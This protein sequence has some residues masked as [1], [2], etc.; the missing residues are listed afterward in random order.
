MGD[1]D[2]VSLLIMFFIF[3]VFS[4]PVHAAE[5]LP[6]EVKWEAGRLSVVS[7]DTPLSD[8]LKKIT[9]ETGMKITGI[10]GAHDLITVNFSG[11]TLAEGIKRLMANNNYI[12]IYGGEDSPAHLYIIGW[13]TDI[14]Y[15][16]ERSLS[17]EL[18]EHIRSEDFD[19]RR[20]ALESISKYKSHAVEILMNAINEDN[21]EIRYTAFQSLA[22]ID[23]PDA[24]NAIRGCLS[25]HE[26][27]VRI[28]AIETMAAKGRDLALEAS[29]AAISD[30]DEL[31]RYKAEAILKEIE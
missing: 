29:T 15:S 12:I 14:K 23:S 19:T 18:I 2:L 5:D 10:E 27:E 26:S 31:V 16:K 7:K 17:A 11:L 28:M 30:A 3:L 9:S 8:V 1:E 25:H 22:Q 21:T 4:Q 24:L 20:M 13:Q 6:Y